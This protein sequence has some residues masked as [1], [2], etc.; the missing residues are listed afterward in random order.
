MVDDNQLPISP[1]PQGVRCWA[2]FCLATATAWI[3]LWHAAITNAREKLPEP[4][5]FSREVLPLLSEHC[6]PCHGPDEK[7][8]KADFRLDTR[9]GA[10]AARENG[11]SVIVPGNSGSSELIHRLLSD[12]PDE[13][14]PPPEV[15]RRPEPGQITLLRRWIDEGAVWGRHWAFEPLKRPAPPMPVGKQ[16]DGPAVKNPIDAFVFARLRAGGIAP[17]PA[18]PRETL[19]R[20]VSLDLIGLP[21]TPGEIDAFLADDSDGA[22]EAVADR[23][24]ASPHFGERMAWDWLDAARYADSNGYQGDADRTMWPWRDWV[25]AASTKTCRLM[26]SPP[27]SWRATFCRTPH[28]S[29]NSPPDSA[30]IT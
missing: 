1:F 17:S 21:P 28:K 24:L 3:L 8:R 19:V 30:A 6:Y 9:E 26:P 11:E 23:L 7:A 12:D 4:V 10:F 5:G 25:V 13:M 20:R 18:A 14:M 15:K 16:A 2:V 29:K 27:G 22:F